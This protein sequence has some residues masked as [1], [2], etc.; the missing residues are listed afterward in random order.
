MFISFNNL[1]LPLL[2]L[3]KIKQ[4]NMKH[5]NSILVAALFFLMVGVANAQDENNPWAI[6]VG[7][8]AVDLYPIGLADGQTT[9][10][11]SRGGLFD[12]YFNVEDHW[13]ILPSVSKL[14][15]GRYLGSGFTFA[16]V[17]TINRID[18]VG[19]VPVD[20]LTYYGVDGEIKYSLRDLLN[21]PGGWFDPSL[22]IGGGYTWVDDI[23]FGTANALA[24]VRFWLGENLALN[25][26]S[27]YKHA[28]EDT[29]GQ[30]HFQHSAG[31][32]FKFGGKDTDGDGI[33]DQDDECPETPGLPEYNGCP[34]T[35]GDGIEDRNDA[36]P[37]TPGVAEYNGCP[38]TD[39]DGIP[40]PQ[41]EC[42]TEA[43]PKSN[44]GC[45]ILDRDG[46]G[47]NDDVDACPDVAGPAANKGCPWPDKDGDGVLDKDDACPDVPGTVANKGCPEVSVEIIKQLNDYSKT[48]LF[49]LGKSTIRQ[50]SYAIL[51][52][53]ADIMKEYPNENFV[54]EGHTDS[55]GSDA[56]N[57]KLS[58][59]RAAS[60]RT[61][62]TTIGMSGNRLSSIGYGESRPIATNA[63]KAGRQQNRRVEISLRK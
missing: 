37:N 44:N 45:P 12:E 16:A 38:D 29:Y 3:K 32:V 4:S 27:T 33:Y 47:V 42:P 7:V 55:Q 18:T 46:D 6:E 30:K 56:T 11:A 34:D 23:G 60:V 17:G 25:F 8:N 26:Q 41:D 5:L 48:I 2:T 49:D 31:V 50:E 43:G 57:Q 36:C 20:D 54:I 59:N 62:L 51:Q 22:G 58:D 39:G 14:S 9:N 35:D 40:D 10:S 63:N 1:L 21:G 24:S 15:I 28:F 13:N 53:I 52:N 19:D 61:Y